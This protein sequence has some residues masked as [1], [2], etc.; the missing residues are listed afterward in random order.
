MGMLETEYLKKNN[1]IKEND[2]R[3]VSKVIEGGS[4]V[5]NGFSDKRQIGI[6]KA[7]FGDS[8]N[9][10]E[11]MSLSAIPLGFSEFDVELW[12]RSGGADHMSTI[13]GDGLYELVSQAIVL[14]DM[15]NF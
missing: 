12:W 7:Q 4:L 6:I 1:F 14:A 9:D 11:D 3:Y 13:S 8:L 5:E 10:V 2:G 15:D